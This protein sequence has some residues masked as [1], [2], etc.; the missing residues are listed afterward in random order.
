MQL[1]D[2]DKT[3]KQAMALS[4]ILTADKITTDALFR[5]GQYISLDEAKKVLIDRSEMSD[6]ERCYQYLL[7]KIAMN[8]MRFDSETNCEKWGILEDGYAIFHI[9]AF[10]DLCKNGGFSKRSFLSWAAKKGIVEPDSQG[11]PTKQKKVNGINKRRVWLRLDGDIS[12]DP[13]GFTP[14][15]DY[16][17]E[18]LPF[19]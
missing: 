13:D 4:V 2:D 10:N 11:N 5:D 1:Y 19:Q 9:P 17:Q 7:G 16:E 3:Q 6:N 18:E 12:A 15:R 14:I 8:N